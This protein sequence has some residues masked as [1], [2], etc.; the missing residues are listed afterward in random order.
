MNSLSNT[1]TKTTSSSSS[2]SR[3]R[4][5]PKS[6]GIPS[7]VPLSAPS[8]TTSKRPASA[9]ASVRKTVLNSSS[10]STTTNTLR[11]ST[12][13][14]K[15]GPVTRTEYETGSAVKEEIKEKSRL[16]IVNDRLR[17]RFFLTSLQLLGKINAGAKSDNKER[18]LAIEHFKLMEDLHM[19]SMELNLCKKPKPPSQKYPNVS[20]RLYDPPSKSNSSISLYELDNSSDSISESNPQPPRSK[21]ST[22]AR[23]VAAKLTGIT[24]SKNTSINKQQ[25][26]N[27]EPKQKIES[28]NNEEAVQKENPRKVLR[29]RNRMDPTTTTP[30][31]TSATLTS[32][33]LNFETGNNPSTTPPSVLTNEI[34][35]SSPSTTQPITPREDL[36]K[37][38]QYSHHLGTTKMAGRHLNQLNSPYDVK[39]HPKLNFL[40]ISD[41][42]NSRIQ[43]FDIFTHEFQFSVPTPSTPHCIA[44]SIFDNSMIVSCNDNY[45]Y[46]Y[47]IS[48]KQQVWKAGG[49]GQSEENLDFPLGIVVDESDGSIF[50]CDTRNH[51]IQ[52]YDATGEFKTSFSPS[53]NFSPFSIDITNDGNLIICDN[54]NSILHLTKKDGT[55]LKS[56]E[57][58]FSQ[59][60][61]VA[62]DRHSGNILVSDSNNLRIV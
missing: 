11:R 8:Q 29:G 7:S 25:T 37:L 49:K 2:Y 40:L 3:V 56:I 54:R 24:S 10:S 20:I 52:I 46:K 4:S 5:T 61:A 45:I 33:N 35:S 17:D 30:P 55:L 36:K 58:S 60:L 42:N 19:Q 6:R 43:F 53:Q 15:E 44:I 38:I 32:D 1:T 14:S 28:N 22:R 57:Q 47:S 31:S 39:V 59:P 48:S 50:V 18:K 34:I 23:L 9:G 27:E 51:R 41:S 62:V 13:P 21:S 16:K 12:T 26:R